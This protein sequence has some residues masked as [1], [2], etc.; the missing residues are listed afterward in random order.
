[1]NTCHF[2]L[3]GKR[4]DVSSEDDAL[5]EPLLGLIGEWQL[6]EPESGD[7]DYRFVIRHGGVPRKPAAGRFIYHG[8]IEDEGPFEITGHEEGLQI[9]AAGKLLLRFLQS[10]KEAVFDVSPACEAPMLGLMISCAIDQAL[11]H[12]GRAMVHAA[13]LEPPNGN[14]RIIL[15]AP[16]GTG[17]TTTAMALSGLGYRI[18]SDDMTVLAPRPDNTVLASGI[19]RAFKVHQKTVEAIGW[20]AGL[21]D[22]DDWDGNGEQWIGRNSVSSLGLLGGIH[23]M[24]LRSV[25]ALRRTGGRGGT[26]VLSG[27]DALMELMADNISL[28]PDG[29][30]PGHDQRLSLYSSAL[31]TSSRHLVEM[32]GGPL[33]VARAVHAAIKDG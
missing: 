14:G 11:A 27:A 6:Q 9:L 7:P 29:L 31:A 5:V 12:N 1:M 17:K 25:V 8:M 20:L 2:D 15:H 18:C 32:E 24:P 13:C 30:F 28:G 19:P 22:P 21:A 23:P 3:T 16:S 33:E 10:S 4:L 26:Q